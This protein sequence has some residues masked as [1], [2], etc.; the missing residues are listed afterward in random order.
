MYIYCSLF[1]RE[2]KERKKKRYIPIGGFLE[3]RSTCSRNR[4]VSASGI[5]FFDFNVLIKL[6]TKVRVLFLDMTVLVS[7]DAD[8]VIKYVSKSEYMAISIYFPNK[9]NVSYNAILPWLCISIHKLY[10]LR[11]C[12]C[13]ACE[14][15][16]LFVVHTVLKCENCRSRVPNDCRITVLFLEDL[17]RV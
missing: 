8:I 1:E 2:K 7:S 11:S 17:L 3:N 6:V 4:F 10:K 9:E 16:C 5:R 14:V 13:T 12:I 15:R